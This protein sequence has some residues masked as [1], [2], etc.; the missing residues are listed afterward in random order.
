MKWADWMA[1]SIR[2]RQKERRW[3]AITNNNAGENRGGERNGGSQKTTA[4]DCGG[5]GL[6]AFPNQRRCLV[7][8]P[9]SLFGWTKIRREASSALSPLT[10]GLL[11]IF[12]VLAS[13]SG[14][15]TGLFCEILRQAHPMPKTAKHWFYVCCVDSFCWSLYT[16]W[17]SFKPSWK[18][19]E[20]IRINK[21]VVHTVAVV[22]GA[23]FSRLSMHCWNWWGC[24]N[25]LVKN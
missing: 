11:G 17:C 13:L 21:N 9:I 14:L 15:L 3:T 22:V 1:H 20:L 7:F 4:L 25:K 2:Q 16:W 5:G 24:A 12:S 8:H 18:G 19:F 23:L 10:Y 6:G